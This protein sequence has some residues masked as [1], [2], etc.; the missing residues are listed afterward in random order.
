MRT[1]VEDTGTMNGDDRKEHDDPRWDS[2]RPPPPPPNNHIDEWVR[3]D[4]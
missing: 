2:R 3:A 1:I 4:L